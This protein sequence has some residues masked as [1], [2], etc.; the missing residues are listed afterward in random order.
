MVESKGFEVDISDLGLGEMRVVETGSVSILICNV[1]GDVF[2]VENQCTHAGVA[3]DDANLRG[4][5]LECELHG[6][7]FDVR[8]GKALALPA[9]RSLRSFRVERRGDKIWIHL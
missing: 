2:A 9:T 8:D 3:F 7:L 5:E 4:C 6:A 1:E